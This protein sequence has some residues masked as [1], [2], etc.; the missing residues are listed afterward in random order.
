MIAK[1]K[2]DLTI[3]ALASLLG[4]AEPAPFPASS[5]NVASAALREA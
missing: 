2:P 3:L 5:L 1:P 4:A